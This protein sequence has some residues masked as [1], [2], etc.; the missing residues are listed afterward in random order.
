MMR[1]STLWR[2]DQTI[3]ADGS[4]PVADAIAAQWGMTA[5]TAR[6]VRSSA[7]FVYRCQ[8]PARF[9]RFSDSTEQ[10]R[11]AV[12]AEV[13][14]LHWLD[15]A[16]FTVA[17]P[18]ASQH[19]E[20]VETVE[21]AWGTFHA[22]LYSALTGEQRQI[23]TL[24]PAR[25]EAWGL[26]LGR[27]HAAIREYVGTN[28]APRPSW[29]DL[30]TMI[31]AVL[32]AD[33]PAVQT[34]L[35]EMRMALRLLPLAPDNYGLCH[36]DFELDNLLWHGDQISVLDFDDCVYLWYVADIALALGDLLATSVA[37]NDPRYRAFIQGYR[38]AYPL[39]D[40]ALL[41]LPLFRRL[42]DLLKYARV[43]RATDLVITPEHPVWLA[44]LDQKLRQR[45]AEYETGIAAR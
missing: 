15:Q 2:V 26:A 11:A 17:V 41:Q 3:R 45:A 37:T 40:Q 36:G 8:Q 38:R 31:A 23:A 18:L 14:L 4:S 19:G 43:K 6:F 22:V 34:E 5:G 1:L 42:A 35:A 20:F 33:C 7:N 28:A 13:Q 30:L 10:Q 29:R 27:L 44:Q 39:D 24:P 12:V 21:T 25:A 16:E 9:L 32:P